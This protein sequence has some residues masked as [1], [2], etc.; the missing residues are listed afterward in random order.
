MLEDYDDYLV[1]GLDHFLFFHILGII[2]PTD[3]Y[4][5]EG[6]NHQSDDDDDYDDYDYDDYD[7]YDE[8]S[9]FLCSLLKD[10]P[11][12]FLRRMGA[13]ETHPGEAWTTKA[14]VAQLR[15]K[16]DRGMMQEQW[17]IIMINYDIQKNYLFGVAL[18]CFM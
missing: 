3:L 17:D 5:S 7:D 18:I 8:T 15:N 9:D 4:V 14:S 1:G 6:L 13:L 2:I 10:R 11:C 12:Y 16:V